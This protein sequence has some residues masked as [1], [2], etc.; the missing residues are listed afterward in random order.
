MKSL[1]NKKIAILGF[2]MEG[3]SSAAFLLKKGA[4]VFVFDPRAKEKFDEEKIGTFE[5]KGTVFQ[6][7]EYPENFSSFDLIL[8][9]PGIRVFSEIIQKALSQNAIVTSHT[10]LFLE[11]CPCPVI[12][13]SG[14]KGKGTTS[15]LIF[16][17][18]KQQ[19]VDAYLG[20]NIGI[21]PLDFFDSLTPDSRVVLEMSSFQLQDIKKSPHIAV[22]LMLVP[23]H[24]DYHKDME[25]YL[26]AKRNMLKFQTEKDFAI[27]NIDYPATRESD[28]FTDAKV[29]H[30]SREDEVGEGCFVR[31]DKVWLRLNGVEKKIID[32]SEILLPGKHN[33]ENVCAATLAASL[34]GVNAENIKKVLKT[35]KGLPHRLELV[36]TIKGVRY[37]DDSF[38]TTPQTAIAAIQAFSEPKILILGGSSKNSD[39]KELGE[40]ISENE[41]IKAIIGIGLEW[42]RIKAELKTNNSKLKIIE[43]CFNMEEIVSEASKIAEIG[44]IVLLS[45]AC[46]SFG[47]FEN[48]KDRGDK[49]KKE[50]LNLVL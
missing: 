28:L 45:P 15:T 10:Q 29:F 4:E 33:W 7:G 49:F 40:I 30:V 34:S 19:G 23:E 44:D 42:S 17:M 3:E 48:Y 14:T 38:S 43:N 2:A 11:L 27:L 47:M 31:D 20:G 12:G 21:P 9:T 35:F 16:E 26:E 22:L 32:V 46:A 13:V 39:F 37:Y 5:K 50:V 6:F 24:L 25:E 36:S 18:L 8:R 1:E 41:S